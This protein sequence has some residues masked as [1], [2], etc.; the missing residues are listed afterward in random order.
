MGVV[1]SLPY[2]LVTPTA[3]AGYLGTYVHD[4]V[5]PKVPITWIL[6][7]YITPVVIRLPTEFADDSDCDPTDADQQLIEA[8]DRGTTTDVVE[9]LDNGANPQCLNNLPLR[10][11]VAAE[12][13]DVVLDLLQYGATL[14]EPVS[15]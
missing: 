4:F 6:D 3:I 9:A 2:Q 5:W 12:R 15:V 8:V 10:L 11:A 13:T 1:L 7:E 14:N